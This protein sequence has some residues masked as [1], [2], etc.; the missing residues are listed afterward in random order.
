MDNLRKKLDEDNKK[1]EELEKKRYYY[2]LGV[3]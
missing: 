1:A 3:I 2:P